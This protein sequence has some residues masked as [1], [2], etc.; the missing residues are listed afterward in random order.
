MINSIEK[1]KKTKLSNYLVAM[2]IP[3]IGKNAAL[4][5]SEQFSGSFEKF[6]EAINSKY[7]FSS[8]EGFGNIMND[9]IYKWFEI[10]QNYDEFLS[11]ASLLNFEV[12]EKL[13]VDENNMFFNKTVV[14]TG[15]FADFTRDELSNKMK[16][17]GAKV[18]GSVSKKTDYLLCGENAGSKKTKAENLSIKIITEQELLKLW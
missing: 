8:I 5:I 17:L 4:T 13:D 14:I 12:Q 7:D 2:N 10:K 15:T 3:L 16:E 1:A 9:E 18:T 6:C 11:V